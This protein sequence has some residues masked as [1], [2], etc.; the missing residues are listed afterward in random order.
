MSTVNWDFS[1]SDNSLTENE[2]G[3]TEDSFTIVLTITD[4]NNNINN[5]DT[6]LPKQLEIGTSTVRYSVTD[7][8]GNSASCSFLVIVSGWFYCLYISVQQ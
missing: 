1:F 5:V 4:E 8:A 6:S 7:A 3:I 2:P